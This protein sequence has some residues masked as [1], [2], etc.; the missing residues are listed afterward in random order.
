MGKPKNEVN[1]RSEKVDQLRAEVFEVIS[2]NRSADFSSSCDLNQSQINQGAP[3]G[4]RPCE[5][6]KPK[7]QFFTIPF[8]DEDQ[9]IQARR[10]D[11]RSGN[12][13]QALWR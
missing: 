10:R 6:Q 7:K 9:R 1:L 13:L 11:N 8:S 2:R 5:I 3:S 12:P 4:P